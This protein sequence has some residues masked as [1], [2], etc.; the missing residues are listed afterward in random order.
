MKAIH[1]FVVLSF[2]I[3]CSC[4]DDSDFNEF[5]YE[6]EQL[7]TPNLGSSSIDDNKVVLQWTNT[8]LFKINGQLNSD[9]RCTP[10]RYV[11]P[12]KFE[13]YMSDNK[14]GG[15]QKIT[16]I[17]DMGSTT[18]YTVQNL[19]NGKPVYFY[20]KSFRKKFE[21]LETGIVTF[22]PG[23]RKKPE[24]I[25]TNEKESPQK[26][27]ISPTSDKIAYFSSFSG[28][29]ISDLNGSS[30]VII[31]EKNKNYYDIAWFADGRKLMICSTDYPSFSGSKISVYDCETKEEKVLF[32]KEARCGNPAISPDGTKIL[33]E[34][35]KDGGVGFWMYNV[36]S[37]K[38]E[39]IRDRNT[40]DAWF[41]YTE[42]FWINN[43]TYLV[44]KSNVMGPKYEI[45]L[46]LVSSNTGTVQQDILQELNLSYFDK[47][48]T[49]SPDNSKIAFISQ[50]SGMNQ[51][52]V[53]ESDTKSLRQLTGYVNDDSYFNGNMTTLG[54]LDNKTLY[55]SAHSLKKQDI[56]SLYR[57]PL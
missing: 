19:T 18:A 32:S 9:T 37:E 25:Y 7:W 16:E 20:A 39:F 24:L 38:H 53:Y 49:P 27:I 31:A 54:W 51:I 6:L 3:F 13:I 36:Q 45:C 50:R 10:I 21:P 44:K 52:W 12:E 28:V 56:C 5:G 8:D 2:V 26:I 1:F 35:L 55:Y 15:F 42:P 47:F 14:E 48:A 34:V 30:T 46:S 40:P 11:I 23:A 57:L 17:K 43:D 33:Y 4:K 29:H 22:T 41:E